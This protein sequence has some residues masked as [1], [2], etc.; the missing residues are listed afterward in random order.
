MKKEASHAGKAR[1]G[2]QTSEWQDKDTGGESQDVEQRP[3]W[4]WTEGEGGDGVGGC[5]PS[6]QI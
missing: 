6:Q 2:L 3:G 5:R 4:V 1:G